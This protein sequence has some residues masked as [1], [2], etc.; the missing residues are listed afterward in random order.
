MDGPELTW[1]VRA[2]GVFC[3]AAA[4]TGAF[5]R[6]RIPR[7]DIP[8]GY[9]R[10]VLALEL[11]PPVEVIAMIYDKPDTPERIRA[12]RRSVRADF[13]FIAAYVLLYVGLA[14]LL[15][16]RPGRWHPLLGAVAAALAAAAAVLDV[17]ENRHLLRFLDDGSIPDGM[18]L[19]AVLK[20]MAI[21]AAAVL[22]S[23]LFFG[24]RDIFL[25]TGVLLLASGLAGLL[26][27]WRGA[28]TEW[29]ITLLSLA[30]IPVL[31]FLFA[32]QSFLERFALPDG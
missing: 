27:S 32:P 17:V 19:M 24:A 8:C 29:S 7:E 31:G 6:V 20:W 5:T 13:L 12:L 21:S 10:P 23:F 15:A 2:V 3:L 1:M 9:T 11:A 25:A 28:C 22:L 14:A 26:T 30:L 4:L 18:R 16:Q